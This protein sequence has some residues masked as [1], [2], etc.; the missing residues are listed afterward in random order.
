MA[1]LNAIESKLKSLSVAADEKQRADHVS[2]V[3]FDMSTGQVD[4]PRISST[5]G[6]GVLLVPKP[7][8]SDE[9]QRFAAEWLEKSHL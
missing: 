1:G 2:V 7:V 8:S 5:E 4:W 3:F 9:W 6:V